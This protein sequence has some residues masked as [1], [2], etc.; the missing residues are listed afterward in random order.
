MFVYLS[1][2]LCGWLLI[3]VFVVFDCPFVGAVVCVIAYAIGCVWLFDCLSV[4]MYV[5]VFVCLCMPVCAC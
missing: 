5:C 2:R 4:S 1:I 3:Y